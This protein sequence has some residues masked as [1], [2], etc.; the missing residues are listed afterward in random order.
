M[1]GSETPL[2]SNLAPQEI[3][4]AV[5]SSLILMINFWK[6]TGVPERFVVMDVI[7][8]ACAVIVTA[9]QLSVLI[10]GV[11]LD[12]IVVTLGVIVIAADPSKSTPLIALAVA[13]F[14]AVA[15]LPVVS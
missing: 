12:V 9:S 7:S 10:V 15:A 2:A 8:A 5:P 1:V 11:A 4:L 3:A 6:L 13:S 14:V